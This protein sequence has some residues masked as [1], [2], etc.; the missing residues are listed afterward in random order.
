LAKWPRIV[1]IP[2]W[3]PTMLDAYLNVPINLMDTDGYEKAIIQLQ[4]V[5]TDAYIG[6]KKFSSA[7]QVQEETFKLLAGEQ[8]IFDSRQPFF[9]EYFINAA[10]TATAADI[11]AGGQ[12]VIWLTGGEDAAK[13][14]R[15]TIQ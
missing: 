2:L 4:S 12:L 15:S 6:T 3:H 7:G 8:I 9:I 5:D 1:S 10:G 13:T 14:S 11:A